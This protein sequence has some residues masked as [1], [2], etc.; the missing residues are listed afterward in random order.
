ELESLPQL[1]PGGTAAV[2]PAQ[3]AAQLGERAGELERRAGRAQDLDR[4][5]QVLEP[6]LPLRDQAERPQG[7]TFGA[8]GLDLPRQ[9]ELLPG[10]LERLDRLLGGEAEGQARAPRADPRAGLYGAVD[11]LGLAQVGQRT[12]PLPPGD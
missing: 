4:R 5:A 1:I 12:G 7:H 9:V 6:L 2:G 8:R 3:R 10:E 11:R